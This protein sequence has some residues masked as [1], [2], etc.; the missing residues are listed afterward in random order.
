MPPR[1]AGKPNKQFLNEDKRLN[2]PDKLWS[3]LTKLRDQGHIFGTAFREVILLIVLLK[4][5][6]E[7]CSV[8]ARPACAHAASHAASCLARQ[9]LSLALPGLFDCPCRRAL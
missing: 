5:L 7:F 6:K 1:A 4:E 2:S 9:R 8:V 3:L